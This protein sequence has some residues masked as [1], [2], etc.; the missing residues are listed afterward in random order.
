MEEVVFVNGVGKQLKPNKREKR[1]Y[2]YIYIFLSPVLL[3]FISMETEAGLAKVGE[4]LY[5]DGH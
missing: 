5:S 4:V 1:E 2:I 3:S